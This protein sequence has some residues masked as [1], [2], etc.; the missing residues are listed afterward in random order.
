MIITCC[1]S[2]GFHTNYFCDLGQVVVLFWASI[3]SSLKG[4]FG[5]R[6]TD[7]LGLEF[8]KAQMTEFPK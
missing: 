7:K 5:K 4:T 3:F 2:L 6:K 8:L 1:Y